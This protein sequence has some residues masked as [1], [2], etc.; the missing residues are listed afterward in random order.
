MFLGFRIYHVLRKLEIIAA[1][2][3]L[4]GLMTSGGRSVARG[5]AKGTTVAVKEVHGSWRE[6][7]KQERELREAA[8]REGLMREMY[9]S[10]PAFRAAVDRA[11]R[12]KIWWARSNT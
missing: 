8:E 5:V 2:L 9:E 1:V 4:G 6:R 10:D 12:P 11:F 7:R 3:T